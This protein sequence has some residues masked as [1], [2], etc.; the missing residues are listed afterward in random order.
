MPSSSSSSPSSSRF[1]A[2]VLA[3]GAI[4]GVLAAVPYKAFDLD[5]YFVPKEL[6]LLATATLAAAACLGG[7]KRLTLSVADLALAAFLAVSIISALF[8]GNWWLASRA[9]GV[10]LGG[11]AVYWSAK[12]LARGGLARAVLIGVACAVTVAALTSL[13]QA[14]GIESVYM[15]VNRAPGGTLGNRNFVAHLAAIGV[16]LIVLCTLEARSALGALAGAGASLVLS[17]ALFMSRSRGAWL[18]LAASVLVIA[19]FGFLGRARWRDAPRARRFTLLIVAAIIGALAA[20]L[21]PNTLDWNST[22]PYLDSVRGVVNY[23]EGSGK[24]RVVQYKN[25]LLMAH[26]HPILGV[27]P[28]NWPVQYPRYAPRTDPSLD[29][30][31]GMTANPWPSSDWMAALGERGMPAVA[32]LLLAVIAIALGAVRGMW[33]SRDATEFLRSLALLAT[34][35]ATMIVGAFDAVLLLALPTLIVWAA[36]GALSP[37]AP[38]AARVVALSDA[39]RPRLVVTALLAG[40]LLC[41]RSAMQLYAMQQFSAGDKI[42]TIER[43]SHAD[44]GSY[45]IHMRLAEAYSAK[46]SCADVKTH[47]GAAQHLFPNAPAPR[48]LLATCGVRK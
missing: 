28:G 15:S 25:T 11:A 4:A 9:L 39:A 20:W 40:L 36:L 12:S 18:A 38:D 6:A 2:G 7:A 32:L 23:K 33:R 27:G 35:T 37:P 16:P 1:A 5:R 42:A 44:P 14:Y 48:R 45:R 17:A 10:S 22:S 43:A 26:A 8:A 47:A 3:A 46:R 13:A 21:V 19:I 34:L 41:A 24:G 31:T 30:D 29:R